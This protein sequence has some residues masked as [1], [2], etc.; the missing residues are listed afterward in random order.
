[1]P[2][3]KVLAA[4]PSIDLAVPSVDL[5]KAPVAE[6]SV[7]LSVAVPSSVA[8]AADLSKNSVVELNGK[9]Y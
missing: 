8:V 9:I 7:D 6:P 4:V 3:T 5:P 2:D 1:M